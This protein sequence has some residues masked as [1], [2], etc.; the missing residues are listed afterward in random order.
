MVKSL[1]GTFYDDSFHLLRYMAKSK[2]CNILLARGA[3]IK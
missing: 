2:L 1:R 3:S